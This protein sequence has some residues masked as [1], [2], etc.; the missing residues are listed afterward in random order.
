MS[1]VAPTIVGMSD[2]AQ[3]E[4][5]PWD[6]YNVSPVRYAQMSDRVLRDA[7]D[8]GVD[9]SERGWPR[10]PPVMPREFHAAWFRGYDD[11]RTHGEQ[12]AQAR[13]TVPPQRRT[14]KV[15]PQRRSA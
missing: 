3:D 6:A 11:A 12:H 8:D 4:R 7:Y 5:G 10:V 2:A 1:A 15:P 13:Q 9:K 14:R